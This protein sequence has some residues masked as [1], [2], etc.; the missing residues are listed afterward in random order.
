[1]ADDGFVT[2]HRTTDQALGELLAEMLRREGI[3]ARFHKVSSTLIGMPAGMI[4]MTV[5]VPAELE[6]RARELIAD[7]EYVGAAEEA[8]RPAEADQGEADD[9]E[10][11]R[12]PAVRRPAFAAA[13]ALFLPGGGHLYAR[14]GG[15]ALV[16]ALGWVACLGAALGA[17][18][19][20]ELELA[21]AVLIA[22]VFTDAV[23]GVRAARAEQ[24]G[25]HQARGRQV[26]RGL[27]LLGLAIV[28]G[29]GVRLATAASRYSRTAQLAKYRLSCTTG[30]IIVANLGDEPRDV[31]ISKIKIAAREL[32]GGAELYDLPPFGSTYL[33]LDPQERGTVAAVVA[34]WL[35]GSCGFASEGEPKAVDVF[36]KGLAAAEDPLRSLSCNYRFDFKARRAG[37][38]D[39]DPLHAIGYCHPSRIAGQEAAGELVLSHDDD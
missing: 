7:L 13:F 12:A 29:S 33:N 30:S 39:S 6:A 11:A 2:I 1:M 25:E 28:A 8:D 34:P 36:L 32:I 9:A 19:S 22:I 35:A 31:E 23:S 21:I 18:S 3:E 20:L 16:L 15:T 10:P 4:E 24:R 17:R 38:R 5:D 37:E 27:G 26:V 14:R